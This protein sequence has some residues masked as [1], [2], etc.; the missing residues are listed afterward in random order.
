LDLNSLTPLSSGLLGMLGV[1]Q[2]VLL[3]A[4]RGA[5]NT[6]QTINCIGAYNIAIEYQ[7]SGPPTAC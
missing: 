6:F 4:A 3:R 2:D 7:V 5:G 1:E